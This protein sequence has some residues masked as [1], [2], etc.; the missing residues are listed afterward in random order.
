MELDCF[1]ANV[2][3]F[4]ITFDYDQSNNRQLFRQSFYP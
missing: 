1:V 4:L 2:D 3:S